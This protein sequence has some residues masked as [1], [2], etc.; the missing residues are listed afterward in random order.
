MVLAIGI[1]A[2]GLV[3]T[4][5]GIRGVRRD[6]RRLRP[7]VAILSGVS[8]SILGVA[9]VVSVSGL[10]PRALE[11]AAL[12][13]GAVVIVAYPLLTGFLVANG[14]VMV[15]RERRSL[16]HLLSLLLGIGMTLLPLLVLPAVG[17]RDRGTV[18]EHVLTWAALLVGGV[19]GY[20]AFAFGAFLLGSVL[21][22]RAGRRFTPRYIVVLGAGLRGRAVSPLLARRLDRAVVEFRRQ[23]GS[24]IIVPSGGRGPDEVRTEASAM[25]DYLRTEHRVPAE[26]ILPEG[27]ART[28]RENLEFSREL[29]TEPGARTVVVTSGFHVLRAAVLTRELGLRARVIGTRT[30]GYYL[31][32]AYLREFAALLLANRVI[33]LVLATSFLALGV[34]Y[35]AFVR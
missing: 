13:V 32:S 21:Y 25:S 3:L 15:R 8:V 5:W 28:T 35:F 20:L 9:S 6:P 34:T 12:A 17:A 31:P 27:R 30:A 10:A 14:I 1:L 11:V 16:Q 4:A 24:A 19:F 7:S 29:F 22:R 33:N 23:G 18:A 26:R 2:L